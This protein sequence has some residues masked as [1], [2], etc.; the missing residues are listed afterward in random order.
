[1]TLLGVVLF[2]AF[3]QIASG[4][5]A[6]MSDAFL[7][8]LVLFS[9]LSMVFGQAWQ[10]FDAQEKR[11]RQLEQEVARLRETRS[12]CLDTSEHIRLP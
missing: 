1:M 6:P 10:E 5:E 4:F 11:I 7:Y 3:G 9:G 8:S 2:Y 12:E